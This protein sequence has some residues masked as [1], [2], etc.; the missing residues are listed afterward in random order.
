MTKQTGM[1]LICSLCFLFDAP[2]TSQAIPFRAT[3]GQVTVSLDAAALGSLNFGIDPNVPTLILEHIYDRQE[4]STLTRNAILAPPYATTDLPSPSQIV[5]DVTGPVVPT[6]EERFIVPTNLLIDTDQVKAT[7][8][9]RESVGLFGLHRFIGDFGVPLGAA[10]FVWGDFHIGYDATRNQGAQTGFYLQNN[11]DIPVPLFEVGSPVIT[12]DRGT[13]QLSGDLLLSPEVAVAFFAGDDFR[14]IGDLTL[15]ILAGDVDF[16]GKLTAA[17]L[18]LIAAAARVH[19]DN[20]LLD[21]DGN[22]HVDGADRSFWIKSIFGTFMGDANLDREFNSS[23][24]IT[25]FTS[26]E[27]EDSIVGNSTWTDVDWDGDGDFGTNDL[28]VSF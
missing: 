22:P 25:V 21:V 2:R 5:H 9:A 19:D 23:D 13:L 14:D 6:V 16:D 11:F 4:A 10:P 24:L 7:W 1:I 8:N 27:Y 15:S 26:C 17:D 20:T 12:T 18:E 3:S 28:V